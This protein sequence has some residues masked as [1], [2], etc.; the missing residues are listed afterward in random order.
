MKGGRERLACVAG[1]WKYVMGAGKERGARGRHV[2]LPRASRSFLRPL[3]FQ[4]SG[5]QARERRTDGG[6]KRSN[7]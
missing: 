1:A 5:R 3:Y 2:C 4:A 7:L 6:W